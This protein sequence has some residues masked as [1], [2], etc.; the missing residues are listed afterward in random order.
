MV[1]LNWFQIYNRPS[2]AGAILQT[3][4]E[5]TNKAVMVFIQNLKN[6]SMPKR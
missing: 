3:A 6:N 4:F 1:I 5:E 2:V